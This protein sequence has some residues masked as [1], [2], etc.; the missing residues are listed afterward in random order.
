MTRSPPMPSHQERLRQFFIFCDA[1]ERHAF[2]AAHAGGTSFRLDASF[3][4]EGAD[5]VTVNFDE[6]HLE[7]LLTRLRQFL[8]DGELFY[9][10]DLRRA[11]SELFGDAADFRSFYDKLV[12]AL[13]R[14]FP[15]RSLQVF[16]ANGKDVVEGFSFK[17]LVEAQLY[18]GPLH[19]ER[20]L[21]P[22]PGSAEE[23]LP[24]SHDA[25]KK[26]LVLDLA[27]GAMKCVENIMAFRNWALR[28]ARTAGHID[29]FPE[30]RAFDT[31]SRAAS[32]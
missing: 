22:T 20:L 3:P 9:F 31:R 8:S 16:K 7:S 23:A 14:P 4:E 11:I 32:K 2:F 5:S 26:Q 1:L 18:T 17:Q 24:A 6:T 19:S 25:A 29:L 28:Q 15:K 12:A 10:K 21:E 30:L 13:H 27:Y